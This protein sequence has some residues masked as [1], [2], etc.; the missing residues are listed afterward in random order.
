M[1]Q[2]IMCTID[3]VVKAAVV[4]EDGYSIQDTFAER[5]CTE[6]KVTGTSRLV[7]TILIT[8]VTSLQTQSGPNLG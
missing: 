8:T 6:N 7:M 1:P 2:P 4:K 3:D 5:F